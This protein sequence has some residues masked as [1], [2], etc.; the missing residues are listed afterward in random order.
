MEQTK[1]M[2]RTIIGYIPAES[3]MY[4][5]HPVARLILFLATGLLPLFIEAPEYNVLFI[6]IIFFMLKYSHVNL[7][8][9]KI[10][11]PMMITVGIIINLTYF[12]FPINTEEG[13]IIFSIGR[14]NAHFHS[15]MWAMSI[16]IRIIALLLASI[17]YFSTNRERDILV[18]FRT[19]GFPFIISYFIGLILRSAGIFLEDYAIIR[20]AEQARGLDVRN[21]SFG[22]KVKHF[23]MYLVPLFTLSI[24]KCEDISIGLFA[25]GT[26]LSGKVDGKKR[27]DY[28]KHK[29]KLQRTDK[30]IIV[31]IIAASLAVVYFDLVV[32][33]FSL[34]NAWLYRTL[35]H[36][37][38]NL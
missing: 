1:K 35:R 26:E 29:M 19:L 14:F 25:K 8:R 38:F 32:D 12:F 33:S 7:S 9:L 31:A 20:E 10:F 34:E 28:L 15:F 16:Y 24:R 11:L 6:I 5:L 23:S 2:Q 36:T 37:W 22:G 13:L 21:L 27:P 17:F 3:P 18:G 4:A 30:W